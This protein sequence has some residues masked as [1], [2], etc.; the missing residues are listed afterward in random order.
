M[1]Y[2]KII[3]LLNNAP[4]PPSKFSTNNWIERNDESRGEYSTNSQFKYKTSNLNSRSCD[5]CDAH[6]LL[7]ETMTI[8]GAGTDYNAKQLD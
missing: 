4:N 2:R 7:I 1:E 8:T 3:N 5:H 6:I